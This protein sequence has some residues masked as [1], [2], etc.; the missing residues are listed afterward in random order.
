MDK[1]IDSV[2]IDV[3]ELIK[4]IT[5]NSDGI[6]ILT[7]DMKEFTNEMKILKSELENLKFQVNKEKKRNNILQDKLIQIESQFRCDNLQ[8]PRIRS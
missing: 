6:K 8:N 7:N 3:G 5:F 2:K 1:K 4:A